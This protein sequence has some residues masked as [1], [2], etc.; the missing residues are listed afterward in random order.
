MGKIN[1]KE[2]L[3]KRKSTILAV[4]VLSVLTL[5]VIVFLTTLKNEEPV[6]FKEIEQSSLPEEIASEIIPQ[7]RTLERALACVI[8]DD[9][10]VIVTRGEKPT[11]GF[12][13]AIDTMA[14]EENDGKKILLVYAK[15]KDPDKKN[16]FSQ[17]ITYPISVVKTDLKALPDNI[18]LRIQY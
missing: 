15:F 7:Y 12:K 3:K 16:A 17:I 1:I 4:L 11:S 5:G 18:E 6:D 13:V 8:D 10:Y 14:L 9:V 2:G